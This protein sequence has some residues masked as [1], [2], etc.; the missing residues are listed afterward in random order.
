MSLQCAWQVM[1]VL[2]DLAEYVQLTLSNPE[3]RT[4]PVLLAQ[5]G[6]VP[7]AQQGLRH[8]VCDQYKTEF[9]TK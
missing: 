2:A 9:V 5:R 6:P 3:L 1:K 4:Q 8:A 7:W